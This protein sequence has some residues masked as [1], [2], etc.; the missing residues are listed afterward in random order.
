[1]K[2]DELIQI[3]CDAAAALDAGNRLAARAARTMT[4]REAA[5]VTGEALGG[6]LADP[7]AFW[8][9]AAF[10]EGSGSNDPALIETFAA[11]TKHAAARMAAGDL[12]FVRESLIGQAQWASIVA[13]KAAAMA[14]VESKPDHVAS[15][16]KLALGA[17]RQAATA[18]CSA[19]AL[20]KLADA[21]M[22]T[23]GGG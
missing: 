17:Q 9:G 11:N 14:Q 18:L 5:N 21:D 23:V 19:A 22:V 20:N 12:A 4:G 2:R 10:L 3:Q 15:L 13:V 1:M 8:A 16:L 6:R 7:S